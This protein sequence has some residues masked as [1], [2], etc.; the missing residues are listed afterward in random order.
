MLATAAAL[1]AVPISIAITES[2]LAVA[3]VARIVYGSIPGGPTSASHPP[4]AVVGVFELLIWLITSRSRAGLGKIRHHLLI[5]AM[6]VL[7]PVLE[8]PNIRLLIWR[9]L[10]AAASLGSIVLC[11]GFAVRATRFRHLTAVGDP[12]YYLRTGG[13]LHHWMVYAVVVMIFASLLEFWSARPR[14]R[15]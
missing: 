12:A 6:F 9:G 3:L 11:C 13:L 2:L 8:S 5:G 15:N 4:L 14:D 1:C 7:L 10:F